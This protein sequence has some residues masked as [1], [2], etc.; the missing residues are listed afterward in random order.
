M[1]TVGGFARLAGVSARILRAYDAEGLFAPA[2]VDPASGYRYYTPAQLPKLR[3][4]LALRDVGLG[5][6][7]IR[8]LVCGGA[9][10]RATL[11]RRRRELEAERHE[12]DRRLAMLEIRVGRGNGGPGAAGPDSD[13]VVRRLAPE[14]VATLDIGLTGGDVGAAFH[15]LETHVRDLGTRAHRP[16]GALPDEDVIFVPLRRPTAPT[17]RIGVRRL[18]A[19]RAATILHHGDYG[20]LP[21]ADEEL[22]AWVAAAGH[23]AA[24]GLRILYLQFGAEPELRVPRSWT[25]E[26]DADFVTELQLPIEDDAGS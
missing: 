5:R 12:L 14:P 21:A 24:G 11:D 4:I 16:P 1:F 9:D 3:R 23:V 13:V 18:P 6:V 20:T 10:L 17:G 26:R 22:R 19:A 25:V 15:E 7:E 2:W 8:D